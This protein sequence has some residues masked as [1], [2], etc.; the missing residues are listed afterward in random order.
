MLMKMLMQMIG[1]ASNMLVLGP[2]LSATQHGFRPSRSTAGAIFF[3]R[4]VQD[5]AEQRATILIITLLDWEKAFGTIQHDRTAIAVRRLGFHHHFVDVLIDCYK[6]PRFYVEGEYVA[7]KTKVQSC[8]L[9]PCLFVLTMSFIDH[10]ISRNITAHGDN[11][12]K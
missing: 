5:I 2:T 12:R 7:S 8:S 1:M 10:D 4:R 11:I 9:S 3:T 6:N